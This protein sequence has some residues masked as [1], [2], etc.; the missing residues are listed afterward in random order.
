MDSAVSVSPFLCYS[1]IPKG[2]G[3]GTRKRIKFWKQKLIINLAGELDFSGAQF[4][5]PVPC[6]VT[7]DSLQPCGP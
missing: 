1:S 4:Q 7:S 5:R 3:G 6:S 2:A